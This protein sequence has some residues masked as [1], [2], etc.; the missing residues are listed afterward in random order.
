MERGREGLGGREAQREVQGKD[1]HEDDGAIEDERERFVE[2]MR[3][4]TADVVEMAERGES[5]GDGQ[6]EE[7]NREQALDAEGE[8]P[9][10]S[11]GRGSRR[12]RAR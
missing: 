1:G 7:A 10:G 5:P 3:R 8:A 9:R 6:E 12:H 4:R 11:C 2:G